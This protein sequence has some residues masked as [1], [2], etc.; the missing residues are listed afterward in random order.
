MSEA[1][2]IHATA[3]IEPDVTIGARTA[4]WDHVHVRS[5]AAIGSDC[6]VGEKT[7]IAGTARVGDLCKLNANVY[8]CAG[9]TLG[10]G[11]MVAAHTVF[12]NDRTPRATNPELTQLRP[13]EPTATTL[14]THVGDGATIGANSTIGPGLELGT[15]CMVGMGSVVTRAVPA[16]ALVAGNPARLRGV[17]CAC[18]LTVA[19]GGAADLPA[20]E[21]VCAC[22]HRIAWQPGATS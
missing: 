16:H 17:V 1:P 6:I 20:G 3:R 21:F 18:G 13:S 12:T 9:V 10:K 14:S 5:G 4:I 15:W 8:V 2:R 11:V 7:Y 22:G 19:R